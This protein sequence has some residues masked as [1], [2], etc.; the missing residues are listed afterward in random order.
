MPPFARTLDSNP[1][2]TAPSTKLSVAMSLRTKRALATP[3]E[4]THLLER[5]TAK[6]MLRVE[7]LS[8]CSVVAIFSRGR[9]PGPSATARGSAATQSSEIPRIWRLSHTLSRVARR[10]VRGFTPA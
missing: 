6:L 10:K 5:P 1:L 4:T 8:G 9:T 7:R 3:P 2:K